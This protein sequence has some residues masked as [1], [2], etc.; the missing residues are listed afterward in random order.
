MNKLLLACGL[1][2]MGIT[3]TSQT[4]NST[5]D[6]DNQVAVENISLTVN[7]HTLLWS[8]DNE[9]VAMLGTLPTEAPE[10]LEIDAI[11][12]VETEEEIEL[13]FDT[14]EYLPKNFD[15]TTFYFDVTA[16]AYI[17]EYEGSDLGFNTKDYLPNNFDADAQPEN[18]MDV[19][20]IET[21]DYVLGFDTAMYLPE[22]FDP[23]ETELDLNTI[24]YIEEDVNLELD[25]DPK[26]FASIKA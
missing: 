10:N 4:E 6:I 1:V 9:E 17:E 25:F 22:G 23:Y 20:Y 15:P 18:F 7:E 5:T 3:T 8:T 11:S 14:K 26:D 16:V 2:F 24:I 12:Y 19:S 13:G 21:P